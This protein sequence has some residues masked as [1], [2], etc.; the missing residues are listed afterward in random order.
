M[1][2]GCFLDRLFQ[3]VESSCLVFTLQMVWWNPPYLVLLL[4]EVIL[5]HWRVLL[6][7][8][9]TTVN[10]LNCWV[11]SDPNLFLLFCVMSI[12]AS[13]WWRLTWAN[14]AFLFHC[15]I[16]T[17]WNWL[18]VVSDDWCLFCYFVRWFANLTVISIDVMIFT[19]LNWIVS[20]IFF[21][22]RLILGKMLL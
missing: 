13:D 2:F 12:Y 18:A 16:T 9:T 11:T 19:W 14:V 21:L 3:H 5:Q 10:V 8:K 22:G 1:T 6:V 4:Q 7:I 20:L 15:I 17:N